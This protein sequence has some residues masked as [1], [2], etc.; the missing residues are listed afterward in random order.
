[1]SPAPCALPLASESRDYPQCYQSHVVLIPTMSV[2]SY[3]GKHPSDRLELGHL[4]RHFINALYYCIFV[5]FRLQE[6][7]FASLSTG[8]G[9]GGSSGYMGLAPDILQEAFFRMNRQTGHVN[10]YKLYHTLG[11]EYGILNHTSNTW[12]GAFG[13]LQNKVPCLTFRLSLTV[14]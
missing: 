6:E 7:P 5:F 12:T 10:K 11:N 14:V 3:V 13:E 2:R 1:L 9:D 8:A 4:E